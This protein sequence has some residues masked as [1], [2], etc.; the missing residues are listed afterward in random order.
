MDETGGRARRPGRAGGRQ[1]T[2]HRRALGR[3]PGPGLLRRRARGARLRPACRR[4]H[5]RRRAGDRLGHGGHGRPGRRRDPHGVRGVPAPGRRHSR[6]DLPPQRAA[7]HLAERAG[8]PAPGR[9]AG[10]GPAAGRRL[11]GCRVRAG[12]L[13]ARRQPRPGLRHRGHGDHGR[14]QRARP[15]PRPAGPARRVGPGRRHRRR[16]VRRGPLPAR[17]DAGPPLRRRRGGGH[18]GRV[19]GHPQRGPAAAR[20]ATARGRIE[21]TGQPGALRVRGDALRRPTAP[22][23]RPSAAATAW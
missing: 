20:R 19:L 15:G 22:S 12:R 21:P 16:P 4:S 5:G 13:P 18:D 6:P 1:L 3:W 2:G 10:R 7:A 8:R 14:V 9:R 11:G 23:T 17:R